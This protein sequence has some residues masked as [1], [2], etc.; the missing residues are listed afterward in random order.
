MASTIMLMEAV[1]LFLG[2]SNPENSKHLA[3][4]SLTLPNLEYDVIDHRPGGGAMS[5]GFIMNSLKKLEPT[6]KLAGIDPDGY[7]LFGI[8]SGQANVFTAY[9]VILDKRAAKKYQ[10]KAIFRG[11]IGKMTADAWNRGNEWGHDYR[12]DEVTRYELT[13]AGQEW[14]H[15]DLWEAPVARVFGNEDSEYASMLGLV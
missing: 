6:F 9:G 14:Y 10:A 15:V 5:V 12:L 8:G 2:D 4:S 7:H 3:I 11:A 1:S 13:I